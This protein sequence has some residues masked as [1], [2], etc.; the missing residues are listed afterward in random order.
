MTFQEFRQRYMLLAPTVAALGI[1]IYMYVCMYV[2]VCV[3][4]HVWVYMQVYENMDSFNIYIL[5]KLCQSQVFK[6]HCNALV[7]VNLLLCMWGNTYVSSF[8]YHGLRHH[9]QPSSLRGYHQAARGG[10]AVAPQTHT[11]NCTF[12]LICECK[13]LIIIHLC[14]YSHLL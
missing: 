5:C 1:Y 11:H 7:F 10:S 9:G 2:S 6:N 3:Y 13:Y 4:V 12:F 14:Y 8:V